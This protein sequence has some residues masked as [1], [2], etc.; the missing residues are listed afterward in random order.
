MHHLLRHR[1]ARAQQRRRSDSRNHSSA[2]AQ[3]FDRHTCLLWD[4]S[5]GP[6]HRLMLMLMRQ[7]MQQIRSATDVS[8]PDRFIV[9]QA[10]VIAFEHDAAVLDDVGAVRDF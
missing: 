8:A 2:S 5:N 4:C 9:H 6:A 1:G 10:R 7:A 3:A